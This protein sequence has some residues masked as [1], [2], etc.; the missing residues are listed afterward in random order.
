MLWCAGFPAELL[1]DK[2]W[3]W[4]RSY[5][6]GDNEV[7]WKRNAYINWKESR[8]DGMRCKKI[9]KDDT[10]RSQQTRT[11]PKI[12]KG[13]LCVKSQQLKSVSTSFSCVSHPNSIIASIWLPY[14]NK[15][16]WWSSLEQWVLECINPLKRCKDI[17]SRTRNRLYSDISFS[18][19][20]TRFVLM[21]YMHLHTKYS[22]FNGVNFKESYM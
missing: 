8:N 21:H 12:I 16:G 17:L 18:A 11:P 3:C 19:H 2:R 13:R 1:P 15:Q 5:R 22:Q 9:V 10:N 4:Y 7:R 20:L 6:L 14:Q